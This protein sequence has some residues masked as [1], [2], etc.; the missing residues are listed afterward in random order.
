[1]TPTEEQAAALDLFGIGD[2]LVIE[3]GA[4]TGKTS[5]LDLLARSTQRGGAY[6]AFNKAIVMEGRSRFPMN[7][8]SRT[9]HSLA[10]RAVINDGFRERLNAPRMRSSQLASLMGAQRIVIELPGKPAKVLAAGFVA[11]LVMRTIR[12]FCLSD[13][14]EPGPQHVPFL[15]GIETEPGSTRNN[16]RVR[17]LLGDYVDAAWADLQNPAGRLPFRP[18]H[19]LA[20]WALGEPRIEGDFVLVDE[21]QDVDPRQMMAITRSAEATGQ[22]LVFVGDTQQ[23]IYGWR[24]AVNALALVE[25]AYRTFLTLS[26]RFGPA[27][28]EAA[29]C[30][31]EQLDAELRLRGSDRASRLSML[32]TGDAV[33]TRTNA[34]GVEAFLRLREDGHKPHLVGGADDVV[35]FAWAA[36]ALQAGRSTE[37]QD[38]ACFSSWAEVQEYV[39]DDPQGDELALL[40]RLLDEFGIDIVIDAMD[41]MIA[42]DAA[43]MVISTAHKA[44][45]REWPR[46]R[47]SGD[48]P[49][50]PGRITPE[51]NRL[52]YVA[53]TRAQD[54]LDPY[55][56]VP[57][58]LAAGDRR[59]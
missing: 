30:L 33:L 37:H 10:Y 11:G 24:G 21:A 5:T 50:D 55:R 27:I 3:A 47:L 32:G 40:V 43:D 52:A 41:G 46:V 16:D 20:M 9:I 38:L 25:D 15:H 19:Y 39:A 59:S 51:E 7:V 42:E 44:K 56:C 14:L 36:Q 18:D 57:Y 48:F 8:E 49:S 31:L 54:V 4:G 2:P 26:F 53:V 1:M 23:S 58:L 29:N 28:A 35:R 13:D 17:D 22:Q 12:E 6:V 34:A 45:G